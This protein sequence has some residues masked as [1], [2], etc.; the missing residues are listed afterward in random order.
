ML[1]FF[2]R[3][4]ESLNGK[5]TPIPDNPENKRSFITKTRKF[6]NT[7]KKHEIFRAFMISSLR[8]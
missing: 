2:H 4:T 3:M 7:K 6:K 1:D 8:G 5:N